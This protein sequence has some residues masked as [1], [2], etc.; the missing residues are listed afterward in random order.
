M[1]SISESSGDILSAQREE[2]FALFAELRIHKKGGDAWEKV[3]R[4]TSS[5]SLTE[6]AAQ[7]TY[8]SLTAVEPSSFR[9]M[10]QRLVMSLLYPAQSCI[11]KTL[12]SDRLGDAALD[13]LRESEGSALR[14]DG[15]MVQ[16]VWL[17]KNGVTYSGLMVGTEQTLQQNRWVQQALG[18]EEPFEQSFSLLAKMNAAMGFNSLFI[19]GPGVGRSEGDATPLTI[20]DAQEVGIAFLENVMKTHHIVLA[21]RSLGGAAIGQAILQHTFRPEI[22]YDICFEMTFSKSTTVCAQFVE[23]HLGKATRKKI[24]KLVSDS[25]CEMDT[26]AAVKKL[27][28]IPNAKTYVMQEVTA[29]NSLQSAF[30]GMIPADATLL[31]GLQ[32]SH[33]STKGV[34]VI[35]QT[36]RAHMS[37]KPLVDAFQYIRPQGYANLLRVA[38]TF[39]PSS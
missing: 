20:G 30:D 22:R 16:P 17:K 34:T 9:P 6:R 26:V 38:D 10:K 2:M 3:Q 18:S 23:Q 27:Q 1:T 13:A 14:R 32:Q 4:L 12:F 28:S 19:N 31:S 8:A 21:G 29:E 33:L 25:G 15:Y 39:F 5:C 7:P 24:A 11:A 35:G 36:D 37:C